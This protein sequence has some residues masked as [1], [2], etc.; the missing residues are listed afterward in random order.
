MRR[1]LP[2]AVLLAACCLG[3]AGEVAAQPRREAPCSKPFSVAA[4]SFQQLPGPTKFA[5]VWVGEIGSGSYGTY[6]SFEVQVIV[7]RTFPPFQAP[8]GMLD[9][10]SLERVIGAAYNT[11]R[12]PFKVTPDAVGAQR[13]QIGFTSADRPF[14]LRVMSVNAKGATTDMQVCW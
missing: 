10:A 12:I 2:L 14:T 1:S 13:A 4:Q 8:R 3:V 5:Y 11:A 9:R 6:K 7:G